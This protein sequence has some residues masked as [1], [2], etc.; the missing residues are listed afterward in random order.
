M[1]GKFVRVE[2]YPDEMTDSELQDALGGLKD[3]QV[4]RSLLMA[5]VEAI[6]DG[7]ERETRTMR[8]LWY[9]LVKP[10]L[11]RAGILDS[12]TKNGKPVAWDKLL[13]VYLA[14]LV[15]E[16]V[17]SY[18]KLYIVDGSRQRQTAV[19]VTE[20]PVKSIQLVGAHY[21]WVILFTEKDTIWG[22]VADIASLYGVSAISGGGE[23][24]TA[25]TEN[26]VKEITRSKTYVETH[27]NHLVLLSLTDYDP[28]G[29]KI[30]RAQFTQLEESAGRDC[31]VH[32]DLLGLIPEQLTPEER[33]KNAY[34]PTETG[35]VEWYKKTGGVDGQPLGLELDALPLSR[36]RGMFAEGIEKYVNLDK[37]RMD[38]RM[39]FLDLLACELLR[40][41]FEAKRRILQ[42]TVKASPLWKENIV[43]ATLS[44]EMF[45]A[46]AKAGWDR[47]DPVTTRYG[48]EPLFDCA[49]GVRAAM[50]DALSE[51][52]NGA[53]A[54]DQERDG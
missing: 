17:T 52:D 50:R 5:E 42:E 37:R 4:M 27:C 20:E 31:G 25:C 10:A 21:P 22:E 1:A 26:T 45:R 33:V 28:Y 32:H 40:P 18:E 36:L 16:G 54:G 19:S 14:E 13:S 8:G 30:A 24:S 9:S 48:N 51:I 6:R 53:R 11:S 23:P 15:R 46:A 2:K 41:D 3:S 39:A 7:A 12:V 49:D 35:L 44:D 38:L 43:K 29:Y 47:I 34:E